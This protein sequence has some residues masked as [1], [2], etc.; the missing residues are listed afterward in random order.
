MVS[1][2]FRFFN[3]EIGLVRLS[4]WK[5]NIDKKGKDNRSYYKGNRYKRLE[6]V[7]RRG[8]DN[9]LKKV[10]EIKKNF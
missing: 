7:F 5:M 10:F 6:Y 2:L 3:E 9:N 8:V 4:G 1:T